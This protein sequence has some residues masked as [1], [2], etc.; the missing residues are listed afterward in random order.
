M[1]FVLLPRIVSEPVTAQLPLAPGLIDGDTKVARGKFTTSNRSLPVTC[2]VYSG[3]P[4]SKLR[5]RRQYAA[6]AEVVLVR[7]APLAYP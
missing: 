1:T 4:I 7:A 6:L 3:G 2:E 5:H